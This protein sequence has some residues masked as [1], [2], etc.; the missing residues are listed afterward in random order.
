M[1]FLDHQVAPLIVD[2]NQD[3]LKIASIPHG[4]Y[5]NTWY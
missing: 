5:C 1:I 2:G 4:I 3:F